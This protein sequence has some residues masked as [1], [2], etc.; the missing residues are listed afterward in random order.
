MEPPT[1][2]F[3][4][5]SRTNQQA[6]FSGFY[7]CFISS[8]HS[9]YHL[10]DLLRASMITPVLAR[11]ARVVT[12][13]MSEAPFR[14]ES[15]HAETSSEA[16]YHQTK[17]RNEMN[18]TYHRSL[19][20]LQL[21]AVVTSMLFV[22]PVLT[23][24]YRHDIGMDYAQIGLSQAAFTAPLLLLN[25][26]SGWIA[27]AFSRKAC[28]IFGDVLEVIGFGIYAFASSFWQIV[29]AEFILGIGVAFSSGADTALM[30]AYAEK[31]HMSYARIS[32]QT[33]KLRTIGEGI[34]VGLGGVIGAANPRLAIGLSAVTCGIGA[35]LSMLII[36]S[37]ERRERRGV[38]LR[39]Q[40]SHAL[41]DMAR[42]TRYALH[43]H[44]PLAWRII[45]YALSRNVTHPLIWM[46]TP[47]MLLAGVP[48]A[49]IGVGWILNLVAVWAGSRLAEQFADDMSE[50]RQFGIGAII[51][52][53]AA[54]GLA[55]SVNLI[56]IC[57]YAGFGFV[58][59][60]FSS[61]MPPIVQEHT[62][63]DMQSTVMSVGGTVGNA[64]YI[65]LVWGFSALGDTTP[66]LSVA[67][68]L[69]L[70]APLMWLVSRKLRQ[71]P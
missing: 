20:L 21:E 3:F 39:E 70:F 13:K 22:M 14:S 61:T 46:L 33:N 57:L 44:K 30:K 5:N 11:S 63:D 51:F 42:I 35:V 43:G 36:E 12:H 47:L 6:D 15:A 7:E 55:A 48:A 16:H 32:A 54:A 52:V 45:G 49:V 28:N 64:I 53:V 2:R 8:A 27:D 58:R 60:W 40:A 37:G 18:I 19:R 31:L 56:T 26:A 71:Y 50:Y 4:Y 59:G 66:Q 38:N 24:F 41:R 29:G 69:I 62:P 10:Y 17:G 65:P 67:G 68:N 25:I 34:A 23:I 1:R 9:S